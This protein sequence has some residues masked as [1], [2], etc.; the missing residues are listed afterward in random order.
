MSAPITRVTE[1]HDYPADMIIDVRSPAEFAEDHIPGAVN[2]PVLD[3]QQ[4]AEIGTMYKQVSPFD[5]KRA[6]AALVAKNIAEHL[7]TKLQ[8]APRHFKPLI[9]CWRG[10]Q[11]SG[12]MARIFSEIGWQSAVIEGGYKAYR[13]T[14]LTMLDNVP[15]TLKLIVVRGR[16]GTAKT[17][18]LRAALDQGAQIID[19]EGLAS[20]R[21]SLL[22]PEPAAP[23][24]AQRQF[25]SQ[26]CA[27]LRDLDPAKPVFI[28]AE[29]NKVGQIHVPAALWA[30]MRG[31]STIAI[32]ASLNAR[33][34]FL[35]KDYD[36]IIN[37]PSRLDPLLDWSVSRLGHEVV[38]NWR[39]QIAA[40]DWPAFVGA[41]LNDHY[42]P[43]Y[44]RSSGSR[45]HK[46]IAT[47]D[48]G[49]LDEAAINAAA[50]QIVGLKIV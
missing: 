46:V 45:E 29:S 32:D 8:D 27:I 47:I 39:T 31:T 17:H 23:Q 48:G 12:S 16:T 37:D 10:G 11:R 14:V 9:Y 5:A 40:N 44:E 15:P 30:A 43:A 28:E 19:L 3:N 7:Q 13:K 35:I 21:G 4:R 26:L 18:I 2:M 33:I 20:H 49:A 36:H 25:E 22:G 24:P 41:L 34:G 50:A 6:G 1:W 42:D 38:A